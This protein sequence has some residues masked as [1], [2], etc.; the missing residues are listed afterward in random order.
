MQNTVPAEASLG[1]V[2]QPLPPPLPSVMEEGGLAVE[3]H[4]TLQSNHNYAL[5]NWCLIRLSNCKNNVSINYLVVLKLNL[6]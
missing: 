3:Q 6:Y 5:F 4:H 2:P 1:A